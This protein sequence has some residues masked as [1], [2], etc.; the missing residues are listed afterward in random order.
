MTHPLRHP[1]TADLELADVLHALSDPVRLGIVREL[2]GGTRLS[3]G[4]LD[5][6]VAKSTLSHHLRV[7]RDAGVT[8]TEP[9]GTSRV[10]SLR[11]EDLDARFPGLLDLVLR[12]DGA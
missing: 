7:L 9:D 6:R 1:Q 4:A 10:L 11:S 2:S 12:A 8:L 5:V 3:C